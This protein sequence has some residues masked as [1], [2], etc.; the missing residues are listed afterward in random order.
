[1]METSEATPDS[2]PEVK[3]EPHVVV[4]GA[5]FGGLRVASTL[6]KEKVRVTVIDAQNHHTFQPLLYQVATAALSPADIAYPI[7][8]IF[9]RQKNCEVVLGRASNVDVDEKLVHLDDGS[10]IPYDHLVVAAGAKTNYFGHDNWAIYGLGLKGVDDAVEIRRRILLA[11]EAA[12]REPDPEARKRL[13][14]FVVI[15]GGP[16]GVEIAGALTELSERVLCDDYQ[17]IKNEKP[18]V[19]LV[20]AQAHLLAGGFHEKLGESAR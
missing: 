17:R 16:T 9:K 1:M 18:R 13:M 10:D 11:F 4:I 2:G 3:R 19:V 7:R 14:T 8:S 15:G 12:E 6:R 5:G 20:E